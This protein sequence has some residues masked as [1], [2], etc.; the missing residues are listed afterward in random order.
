MLRQKDL[1]L[2]LLTSFYRISDYV[3]NIY[4]SVIQSLVLY[5]YRDCIPVQRPVEQ[6]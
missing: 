5:S 6:H 4:H 3:Y 1:G 2:L